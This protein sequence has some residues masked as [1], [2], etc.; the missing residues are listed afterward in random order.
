MPIS[1]KGTL[2]Q[3]VGRLNRLC[4]NKTE[5]QV[6]DYVDVYVNMLEKMYNKRLS[7]YA[8]L[9]YKTKGDLDISNPQNFIYNKNNFLPVYINDISNAQQEILIFSPFISKRK[10]DFMREHFERTKTNNIKITVVT[11]PFE[12][13]RNKDKYILKQCFETLDNSGIQL[14]FKSKI[15]QKFA[16]IDQRIVWYGSINLLSFGS[17]EESIMRLESSNIANELLNSVKHD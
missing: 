9:G 16:V 15:H 10:L 8:S 3:Y 13:F 1:W 14:L 12:D 6:Y 7:G 4:L 11:R 2:Q 5:V 17:A